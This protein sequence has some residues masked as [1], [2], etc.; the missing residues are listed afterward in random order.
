MKRAQ[1]IGWG[2]L[3]TSLV[4]LLGCSS[5]SGLVGLPGPGQQAGGGPPPLPSADTGLAEHVPQQVVIGYVPGVQVRQ[6]VDEIKGT[7]LRELKLHN[8]VV[9]RLPRMLPCGLV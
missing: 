4:F 8:A 1:R 6:V 3:I 9:V 7:L 2:P 5:G